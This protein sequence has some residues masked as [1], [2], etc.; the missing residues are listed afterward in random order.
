MAKTTVSRSAAKT[1][2]QPK[3]KENA[4]FTLIEELATVSEGKK[5]I[6]L[7]YGT[8]NDNEPK[9]EIRQMKEIDGEEVPTKGIGLTQQELINLY[10][11]IGK[12]ITD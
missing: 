11:E 4:K 8:W 2:A 6:K 3:A 9:F 1:D 12:L 10:D 7:L 5:V